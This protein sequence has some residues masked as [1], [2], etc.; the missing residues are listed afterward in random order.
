MDQEGALRPG[1]GHRLQ[2]RADQSGAIV[3]GNNAHARRQRIVDM[4]ARA[5]VSRISKTTRVSG[6]SVINATP[7]PPG[8][9]PWASHRAEPR[10]RRPTQTPRQSLTQSGEPPAAVRSTMLPMSRSIPAILATDDGC[11][12]FNWRAFGQRRWPGCS[13]PPRGRCP[14]SRRQSASNAFAENRTS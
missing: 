9:R 1:V 8:R 12:P 10:H 4:P 2:D 7:T 6:F 3:V 11:S 13:A 5:V 14:R